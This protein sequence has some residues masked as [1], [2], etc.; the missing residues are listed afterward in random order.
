[1]FDAFKAVLRGSFIA[2]NAYIRNKER[3]QVI[4]SKFLHQET[5]RAKMNPNQ[6]ERNKSKVFRRHR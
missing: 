1:M 3:S 4:I 5:G 2:L 6:V